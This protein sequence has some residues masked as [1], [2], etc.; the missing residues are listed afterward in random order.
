MSRINELRAMRA[1]SWE[2]AKAF[3]DSKRNEKGMLNAEDTAIYEKMESDIVNLGK[4]IEREERLNALEREMALPV[5]API[6]SKP[7]NKAIEEKSG[8]ASDLYKKAFW[9][10]MRSKNMLTPELSNVLREGVDSEGGYLVPDEYENTLVEALSGECVIRNYAHVFT[11]SNGSHK[12]P[13]VASKGEASWIDENGSY[14]ESDDSFSQEQID[15]HKL[16]TIIKVS[17]EL[18]NDSAFNLEAYFEREFARRIAN[19]EEEAFISGNGVAKPVGILNRAEVG[20]TTAS[21]SAINADEV[22]DLFYSLKGAYRRNAIWILNDETVK[23]IRK[24]K[25]GSGQYLWQPGLREGEPDLLLGKPLKTTSYMPTIA[26]E[27]KPIIFGDL[28]YYWIGDR[29]GIT[30]KRLNE[31]YADQGQVGFLTSKRLDAKL[32]LPEAVKTLKIK[33][34]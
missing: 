20:V 2:E 10:R 26:A 12:I 21:A 9:N 8:R 31:K 29:Q 15:A 25:D 33:S 30:F 32:I 24:L 14:P 7:D 27:A 23:A 11:T 17:E 28:S 3:L 4:E 22:M 1:K 34:K 5:N 13:V 19:K 16:G 6:T 18:L